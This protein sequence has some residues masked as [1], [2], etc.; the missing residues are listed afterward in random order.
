MVHPECRPEVLEYADHALS[1]G[2]MLR[3]LAK[4]S[5]KEFIVGTEEGILHR[6]GKENPD[7]RFYSVEPHLICED[8]KKISLEDVLRSL[9]EDTHKVELPEDLIRKASGAIE[10]MIAVK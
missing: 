1:T 4:S 3:Y 5:E 6:M 8:M 7:K 2:A 10:R 9:K